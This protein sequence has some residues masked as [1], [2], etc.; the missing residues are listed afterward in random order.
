MY[1]EK[2]RIQEEKD[3]KKREEQELKAK[4][5]AEKAAR[6]QKVASPK[7]HKAA[8]HDEGDGAEH[9]GA[10]G[11]AAGDKKGAIVD[12]ALGALKKND[13]NEIMKMVRQRRQAAN[14]SKGGA[15]TPLSVPGRARGPSVG[16]AGESALSPTSGAAPPTAERR[17]SGTG[18]AALTAPRSSAPDSKALALKLGN[19]IQVT[20]FSSP[21]PLFFLFSCI[22]H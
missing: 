16:N 12:K 10:G 21:S 8:H 5:A 6:E 3:R 13:A 17:S 2:L 22:V 1:I 9:G 7:D 15:A 19:A 18:A 11:G 14:A 4:L 20:D